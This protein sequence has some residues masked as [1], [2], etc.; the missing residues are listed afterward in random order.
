MYGK[1]MDPY[2][3]FFIQH[4]ENIP[5]DS[6]DKR[7]SY[8]T[9][10]SLNTFQSSEPSV[11]LDLWQY[12]IKYKMLPRYFPKTWAERVLFIGQTVLMFNSDPRESIK[13]KSWN[14]D[15]G[16]LAFEGREDQKEKQSVWGEQEQEFYRKF[17][18]LQEMDKLTV[19]TFEQIVDEIK[20]CVTEHLSEIAIKEADLVKQ[21]KLIKDFFL[22][23][24]GELFYEFIKGLLPLYTNV[25][26]EG[27]IRDINRA[28]QAA[29]SSVNI[30]DEMDLFTFN[31]PK[32]DIDSFSYETKG[33]FNFLTLTYKIKWPLHLMFPPTVLDRYNDLFRFLMRIKKIQYDLHMVWC[34]HREGKA[35]RNNTLLQFRNKLMF[36]IDNLQY[37]LQVDVLESQFS[38]MMNKISGTKDFEQIQRAHNCFQANILGLCFLLENVSCNK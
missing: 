1:F 21:L 2:G 13:S 19:L 24:R 35:T 18:R 32:E 22:L 12:E 16:M 34:Y 29:A 38:I 11:H 4:I 36:L 26:T 8:S 7:P 6:S 17:H 23:G 28:F 31:M 30:H 33:F 20:I 15:G 10:T 14:S 25:I 5:T 27:T 3:E 9:Q 37:Y